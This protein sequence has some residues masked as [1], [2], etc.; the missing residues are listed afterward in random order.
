[1][2]FYGNDKDGRPILIL[3]CYGP[4]VK[5]FYEDFSPERIIEICIMIYE[6]IERIILPMCSKKFNKVVGK[7]PPRQAGLTLDKFI[8]IS[9]LEPKDIGDLNASI[10]RQKDKIVSKFIQ[11]YFPHLFHKNY[12]LNSPTFIFIMFKAISLFMSSK[13]LK[14]MVLLRSN[15]HETLDKDIGLDR[16]PKCIGGTNPVPID[17]Y[18]N[19]FDAKYEESFEQR[20]I[21]YQ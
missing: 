8:C 14:T 19:F 7:W 10:I 12:V 15:Y 3:R 2:K 5:K 18:K 9:Y 11:T 21:V 16:L 6:R 4:D 17:E 13:M 1:M 20:R